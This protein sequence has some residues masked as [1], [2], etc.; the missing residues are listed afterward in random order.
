M[1][2]SPTHDI[3]IPGYVPHKVAMIV[4]G[5]LVLALGLPELAAN[6]KLVIFGTPGFAQAVSVIKVK[7]G[8]PD[9]VFT[10]DVMVRK[11]SEPRDR[12][13]LFWNVFRF[14]TADGNAREVRLPSPGL[15]K[16][17][18]T[19]NDTDGLPTMLPIYHD[20]ANPDIVLFPSVFST[21]I[22]P[23]LL[24]F[25]GLLGAGSGAVLLYWARRPIEMPIVPRDSGPSSVPGKH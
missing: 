5:I 19:I 23:S 20:P 7:A 15:L 12:S 16:P 22:F 1:S 13:Y 9:A 6:L 14:Q 2:K 11:N 25:I 24:T 10:D 4:F 8:L 3:Y 18:Y 17:L 21:W